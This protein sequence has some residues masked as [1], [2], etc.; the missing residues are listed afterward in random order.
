[1][2]QSLI[3]SRLQ[4]GRASLVL[5][6][7]AVFLCIG[8]A[9]QASAIGG[10]SIGPF[11]Q[12]VSLKQGQAEASFMVTVTNTTATELPLR[13]TVVDF[14]AADEAGGINFL[15][16][17]DKLERR[18]GLA[19]W[20]RPEK[21]VL[22]LKPG[23]A[24]QV[25]VTIENR[26]SLSP[27]GHYGAVVFRLDTSVSGGAIQ[28]KVNFTK[29]VSTLVLAKKLGGEKHS[30]TLSS[31]TWSG[32]PIALP[33]EA[34]LRF[35]NNGN[36]HEVPNGDVTVR[37]TFGRMLSQGQLNPGSTIVLPES[38]RA[39]RVKLEEKGTLWLP[40]WVT[41]TSRY[42]TVDTGGYTTSVTSFFIATPRTVLVVLII[43]IVAVFVIRKRR[44]IAHHTKHTVKKAH[45]LTKKTVKKVGAHRAKR[46]TTRK[47]TKRKQ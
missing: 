32:P 37:D 28:P 44:R 8:Y 20:M 27:G 11:L 41:V 30:L 4:R 17:A 6:A 43:A 9:P 2:R 25:K 46:K 24:Q 38:I 40:G 16:D 1:M 18:Y 3:S 34:K 22:V 39:Y 47:S 7:I 21:D 15:S 14:G 13:L 36:V 26:E 31:A 5:F 10:L 45:A 35:L 12:E 29:A 42:R 23:V 33:Q 19:S